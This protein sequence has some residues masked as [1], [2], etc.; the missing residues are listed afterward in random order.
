MVI[1]AQKRNI[2]DI[3]EVVANF[4]PTGICSLH[5]LL[6]NILLGKWYF[7]KFIEINLELTNNLKRYD[8]HDAKD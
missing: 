3:K 4:I 1:I 8:F 5:I 2:F 7:W 6:T